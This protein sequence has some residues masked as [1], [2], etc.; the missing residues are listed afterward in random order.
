MRSPGFSLT[1]Q[2]T[3]SGLMTSQFLK[4]KFQ[5]SAYSC[6]SIIQLYKICER[7]RGELVQILFGTLN[8]YRVMII[9][10]F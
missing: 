10:K 1:T 6:L 9:G 7:G 8:R 2:E 3:A 4:H 5:V